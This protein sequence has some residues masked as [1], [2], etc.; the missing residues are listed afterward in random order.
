MPAADSHEP[1]KVVFHEALDQALLLRSLKVF[2]LSGDDISGTVMV[3]R[4]ENEWQFVPKSNWKVGKYQILIDERLEDL[5]GKSVRQS[6]EVDRS[7]PS[8]S[9]SRTNQGRWVFSVN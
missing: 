1:L 7:R 2:T 8:I 6:F 4:Q 5:A 9:A 3:T